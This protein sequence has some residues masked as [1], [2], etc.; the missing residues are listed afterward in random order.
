MLA[1]TTTDSLWGI[2]VTYTRW[3]RKA[4]PTGAEL[5]YTGQ[6]GG[7]YF[8][9]KGG[10]INYLCLPNDPEVGQQQSYDN[11]QLYGVEYEIYSY[12]KPHGWSAI[13]NM[14]VPCAVCHSRRKSSKVIIPGKYITMDMVFKFHQ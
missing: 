1:F 14:E 2:G 13:G 7:N 10:G 3:G 6:A 9:N 11:S 4:C 12:S 8:Q 5:V